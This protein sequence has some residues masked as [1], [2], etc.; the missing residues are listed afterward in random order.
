VARS[1][2][3]LTAVAD[4]LAAK[5]E[6]SALMSSASVAEMG[7]RAWQENR[8]VIVTGMRNAVAASLIRFLPRRTVLAIIHRLQSPA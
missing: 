5:H 8:R 4:R 1:E 7:Y 3:A 2:A 6:V